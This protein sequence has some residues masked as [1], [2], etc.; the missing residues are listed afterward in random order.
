[1]WARWT[2]SGPNADGGNYWSEIQR[3]YDL[4]G[5]GIGDRPHT[6]QNVFQ[7]LENDYPEV[8]FYLFSL[9]AQI[10]EMAERALP[11]LELWDGPRTRHP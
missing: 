4:D 11:I 1:M 2:S 5:D 3:G 7:V 10:L 6:I 8:R 9:A